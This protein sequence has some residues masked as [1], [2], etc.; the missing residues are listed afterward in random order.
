MKTLVDLQN[1]ITDNRI[2]RHRMLTD[3][4]KQLTTFNDQ[5][6]LIVGQFQLKLA[7][8]HKALNRMGLTI[9]NIGITKTGMNGE[10][11]D[12][13]DKLSVNISAEPH[14]E[15]FKFIQ[16]RGYLSNGRGKNHQRLTDKA[17]AMAM[18]LMMDA[19]IANL[20]VNPFSLQTKDGDRKSVLI[21]I[22][23]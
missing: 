6:E 20:H 5:F 16:F 12:V 9:T 19:D 1:E 21:T 4:I 18:K 14:S 11:W 10:Q 3:K 15:K 23:I 17:S 8:I 22:Y 2:A 13:D 7:S